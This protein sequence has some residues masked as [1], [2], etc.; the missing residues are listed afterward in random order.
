VVEVRHVLGQHRHQ[1]AAVDDQH[2]VEQFTA[3]GS[4]PS[5][6]DSV[7]P[8]CP[9]RGAQDMN[10]FAGEHGIEHAVSAELVIHVMRPGRIRVLAR[11]V[12]HDVAGEAGM[13]MQVV[14][15]TS[16]VLLGAGRSAG[17]GGYSAPRTRLALP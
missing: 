13:A 16:V 4:D 7:R 15:V 9:H 10:T 17:D 1:M 11:R 6:G 8:R 3:E 12:D 5:F 2:P 14:V